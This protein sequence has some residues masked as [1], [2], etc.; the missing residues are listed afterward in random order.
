MAALSVIRNTIRASLIFLAAWSIA[1]PSAPAQTQNMS[2][3]PGRYEIECMPSRKVLSV[4][5]RDG[6]TIRQWD[7]EHQLNQQWDIE[8]AGYGYIY[9]KSA[10]NGMAIDIEGGISKDEALLTLTQPGGGETQLW[11]IDDAGEGRVMIVSRL[12]R[13]VDL[14]DAST[15]NGV[16]L[17]IWRVMPLDAEKFRLIRVSGPSPRTFSDSEGNW[18]GEKRAYDLGYSLGAQD[19]RAQLRRTFQRHRGEYDPQWQDSFIEGYYDGYD[20][21]RTDKSWIRPEERDY[22]D[23][24][25]RL[26]R[27]DYQSGRKSNYTRY[28]DRYD[29][30]SEATF[31]RG[32][33]DGYYSAQ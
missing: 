21:G 2:V 31:R 6:H 19:A 13:A 14:P 30:R 17:Q 11:R 25:Y 32:Y 27:Q 10:L 8:D 5:P 4:D 24:G 16:R 3:A 1:S 20:V 29:S 18:T 9:I 26:G 33:E 15:R 7:S 12:G 28:S 23:A 22:Y